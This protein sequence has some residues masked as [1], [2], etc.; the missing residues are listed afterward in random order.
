MT[1]HD[2]TDQTHGKANV[3][4]EEG[5]FLAE[6]SDELSKTTQ[7]AKWIHAVSQHEDHPGQ[8]L[9]TCEHAVIR[10]REL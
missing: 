9:A 1:Q 2:K 10:I 8:T 6:H 7:Q 4:P 3:A 5:R